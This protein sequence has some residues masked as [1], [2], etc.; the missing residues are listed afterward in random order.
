MIKRCLI[1]RC[2]IKRCLIKR[3]LIKRCLINPMDWPATTP[4]LRP[5]HRRVS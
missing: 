3:C 2:L 1:K 5:P 4:G